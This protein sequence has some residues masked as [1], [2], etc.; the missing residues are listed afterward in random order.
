VKIVQ[1]GT[2]TFSQDQPVDVRDWIVERE[3][4]DPAD[5]T[6]EQLLLAFAIHWAQ[7]KLRNAVNSEAVRGL[8]QQILEKRQKEQ[9]E[10]S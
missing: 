6:P 10:P 7:E 2:V 9:G 8:V 3:P 5:A 1:Y 4:E